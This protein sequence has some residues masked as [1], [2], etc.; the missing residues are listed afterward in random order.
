V[1]DVVIVGSVRNP[2]G[3]RNGAL[4][5]VHP[6]DPS[7]HVLNALAARTGADPQ[8]VY[9]I[10]WRC[11]GQAG[12]QTYD[13]ARNT[14]LAAGCPSR[15][16]ASRSTGSAG[17]ASSPCT[18]RGRARRGSPRRVVAGGVESMQSMCARGG[19]AN[20]RILELM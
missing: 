5:G 12:E 19:Q 2:M 3:K 11:V 18:S 17:R 7:A 4:A 8:L 16:P 20:A 13:I 14:V 15:C 6:T 10:I 1:R 9:D